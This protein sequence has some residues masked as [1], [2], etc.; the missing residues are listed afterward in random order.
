M[1]LCQ[2]Q[3]FSGCSE[4][5]LNVKMSKMKIKTNS[6]DEAIHLTDEIWYT[7]SNCSVV[8]PYNIDVFGVNIISNTYENGKGV[9]KFDG[10][11]TSIG[12][13]AFYG[14]SYLTSITI[15]NS[16]TSICKEAFSACVSLTNVTI[17]NSVASIGYGAFVACLP[18]MSIIIPKSVTRIG[19]SAFH[20]C[21]SL[22]SVY[23]K[24][25]AVPSMGG[26]VF[27]NISPSAK[28]YVPMESVDAYKS[29]DVWR[30][31]ADM[32]VGYNFDE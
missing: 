16:V 30:E 10:S 29:A 11:V 15:P 6:T 8:T 12:E 1:F 23:C 31:F 5:I 2:S 26:N 19:D 24:A 4:E 28:I 25:K 21:K 3:L 22:T 17:S 32:I 13:F 14:C 27:V 9:I 20:Y 18:L 7:S